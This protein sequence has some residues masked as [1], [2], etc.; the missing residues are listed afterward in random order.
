[1]RKRYSFSSRRTRH[2]KK[3]GKQRSK[4]PELLQKTIENSDIILEILDARFFN[5]MINPKI[6]NTIKENNKKLIRVLNKTDLINKNNLDKEELKKIM[7]Y[8]FLSCKTRKGSKQLREKIK[9]ESQKIKKDKTEEDQKINIGI[10]GYPNTGK[11]SLINLLIGKSSAKTGKQPGFTKGIQK[12]KLNSNITL[13]DSPGVIPES[14]YSSVLT[15]KISKQTKFNARSYSQV[16]NPELVIASLIKEHQEAL[17]NHY[18]IN[19]KGD[20]EI[21][22]K[23]LGKQK[24]L[25]KKAGEIDEDKTAR[26]ILKDWQNGDIKI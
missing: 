14:E 22:L 23:K 2:T 7:P 19:A 18:K 8:V 9:I 26:L 24:N 21:L 5:E 17:E 10:I 4:F 15:N 16:K 1:M 20:S 6:E 12:L 13:L 11:S 25:F 3:I